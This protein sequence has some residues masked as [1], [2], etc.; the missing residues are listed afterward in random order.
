MK[1]RII[2]ESPDIE[3]INL[4]AI[5]LEW[6]GGPALAVTFRTTDERDRALAMLSPVVGLAASAN[7]P[8]DQTLLLY[9]AAAHVI[10]A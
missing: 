9:G 3:E 1:I 7:H 10:A 5:A 8:Q 6:H 4:D 2:P